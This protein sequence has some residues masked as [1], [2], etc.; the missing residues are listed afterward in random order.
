M[1]AGS[2]FRRAVACLL[3]AGL[4]GCGGGGSTG[5][6]VVGVTSGIAVDPYIVGAKFREI[7]ADGVEKD[8]ISTPTDDKGA[9]TFSKALTQGS[10]IELA[11]PGQ[12]N[13]AIYDAKLKRK[14]DISSGSLVASPITTLLADGADEDEVAAALGV[15]KS[16]LKNNPMEPLDKLGEVTDDDLKLLKASIMAHAAIKN[17][18]LTVPQAVAMVKPIVDKLTA[19]EYKTSPATLNTVVAVRDYFL[20]AKASDDTLEATA[21]EQVFEQVREAFKDGMTTVTITKTETGEYTAG[22]GAS[23]P[24]L[25]TAKD[26][27]VKGMESLQG[28]LVGSGSMQKIQEAANNFQFAEAAIDSTTLQGDQDAI[29]FFAAFSQLAALADTA[30]G[31]GAGLNR[32]GDLLD[33]FGVAK[34]ERNLFQ[35][36]ELPQDCQPVYPGSTWMH[37]KDAPLPATAPTTGAIQS[38]L[39]HKVAPQLQAVVTSLGKVSSGFN[40]S[41][42][43]PGDVIPTEIDHADVL[44]FKAAAQGLL[45]QINIQ[46]AYNV[47]VD[48]YKEQ[49]VDRTTQEFLAAHPNLGKLIDA[50]KLTAAKNFISAGLNDWGSAIAAIEDEKDDQNDDLIVFYSLDE[51]TRAKADLALAKQALAGEITLDDGMSKINAAKFFSPGVDLRSKVPVFTGDVPGLFPDATLG[52]ILVSGF[53]LNADLDGDGSP[54]L[55]S[56]FSQFSYGVLAQNYAWEGNYWGIGESGYFILEGTNTP[57]VADDVVEVR[58]Y[59]N[60]PPIATGTWAVVN[61]KLALTIPHQEVVTLTLNDGFGTYLNVTWSSSTGGSGWGSLYVGYGLR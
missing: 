2:F 47:D 24:P 33:A 31:D 34:S 9:F 8:N 43:D 15:D 13:G 18:T 22:G 58:P 28:G 5:T 21:L 60:G 61:G 39:S 44:V 40:Y 10:T 30:S 35:M 23:A 56:D 38:F 27:F 11:L 41:W 51:Q 36:I 52:G 53:E 17:P 7:G 16:Q 4:A 46:Q 50:S 20:E 42:A 55:L 26:Y 19:T 59:F 32:M 37:C 57:S 6:P 25:P 54:D 48:L 1:M 3:I 12:H 29:R 45:G 14:V 49:S